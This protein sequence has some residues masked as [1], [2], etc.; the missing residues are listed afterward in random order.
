MKVRRRKRRPRQE[1]L[2]LGPARASIAVSD[3]RGGVKVRTVRLLAFA[4]TWG[5]TEATPE[6]KANFVV[7]HLP[8]G[9][10]ARKCE[11]LSEAEECL[12]RLRASK[13]KRWGKGFAFGST[14][15]RDD[16]LRRIIAQ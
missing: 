15:H 10:A 5:V 13:F 8:T 4:G 14:I 2:D 6:T 1:S 16:D 3:G 9:T 11:T 12:E 7:T